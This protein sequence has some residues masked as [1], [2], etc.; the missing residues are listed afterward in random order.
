MEDLTRRLRKQDAVYWGSPV[1]DGFGGYDFDDPVEIRVRWEHKPELF[2]NLAGN[3]VRSQAVVFPGV[4]LDIGGYLYLGE[5]SDLDSTVMEPKDV[6]T[7]RVYEIRGFS[8]SPSRRGKKFVRK[9]W[10]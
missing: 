3:E 2:I 5:L 6:T 9:V 1:A 8:K 7:G 10:L 4:D